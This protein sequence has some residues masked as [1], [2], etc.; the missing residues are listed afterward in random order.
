MLSKEQSV[1]LLLPGQTD[2]NPRKESK[3]KEKRKNKQYKQ[4]QKYYAEVWKM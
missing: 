4:K 1:G 3:G 2:I